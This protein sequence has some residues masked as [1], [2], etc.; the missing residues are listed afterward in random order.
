MYE[1]LPN[2]PIVEAVLEI[3]V[4]PSPNITTDVLKSPDKKLFESFP[5]QRTRREIEGQY[6][7]DA[8]EG[9]FNQQ[10]RQEIT[11][12]IYQSSNRKQVLQFLKTRYSFNQLHPYNSWED[13]VENAR[14][15][16]ENY[17]IGTAE[18]MNITKLRLRFLNH[19]HIPRTEDPSAYITT[20][21]SLPETINDTINSYFYRIGLIDND[22]IV[23]R[24][25]HTLKPAK[26]ESR[27]ILVIDNSVEMTIH[28]DP[29]NPEIW[30]GFEKLRAKYYQLFFELLTSK[31][32]DLCK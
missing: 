23:S 26:D 7:L 4:N 31:A 15:N 22:D 1:L 2:P 30:K 17:Y 32:I 12:Y 18:P 24:A 16:W 28:S 8:A 19:L 11:G 14:S 21:P 9:K 25:V 6:Q 13:F 3:H 29:D 10:T 20:Y 5:E 27:V